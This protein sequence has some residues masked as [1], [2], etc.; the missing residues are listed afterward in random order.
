[1]YKN[2]T[3]LFGYE[4]STMKVKSNSNFLVASAVLIVSAFFTYY[5]V[6]ILIGL[7]TIWNNV[8]Y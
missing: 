5:I 2:Q 4:I 3:T 6:S 7:F 1:M 8:K